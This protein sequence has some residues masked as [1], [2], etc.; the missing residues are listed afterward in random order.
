MKVNLY[1]QVLLTVIA[2]CMI[3]NVLKDINIIPDIKANDNPNANLMTVQSANNIK[4]NSDGSINVKLASADVIEVKPSYGSVFKVEPNSSSTEFKVTTG[5]SSS[6]KVEPKDS[7]TEFNVTTRSSSSVK[8][9]PYSYNTVYTVKPAS[10]AVFTV[11]NQDNTNS[12]ISQ[13]YKNTP[14]SVYPNP[15][16]DYITFN[17]NTENDEYLTIFSIDGK[18]MDRVKLSASENNF[19]LNVTKYPQGNYIYA[20]N[21]SSGKFIVK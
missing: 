9:E 12:L 13:E 11:K 8:T 20:M 4:T 18:M 3:F 17:Y 6:L 7:Y 1:T 21:Q 5:Y 10:N 2:F 16:T 19:S 14:I 15:A